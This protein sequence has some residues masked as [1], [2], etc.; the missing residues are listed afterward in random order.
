ML[1][2]LTELFKPH[3]QT[4]LL[5]ILSVIA[6]LFLAACGGGDTTTGAGGAPRL[7]N[8]CSIDNLNLS[9]GTS[10]TLSKSS[11][12]LTASFTLNLTESLAISTTSNLESVKADDWIEAYPF[13]KSFSAGSHNITL[14]YDL[15]SPKKTGSDR[16]TKLN[17]TVLLPGDAACV[18]NIA[19]NINLNP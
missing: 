7:S 5:L 3:F 15:N 4:R 11:S 10:A 2:S 19:T 16:Y 6:S 8:L 14:S 9:S 1:K 18:A 12:E 17:V 13:A